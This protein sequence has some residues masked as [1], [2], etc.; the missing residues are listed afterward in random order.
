MEHS[1]KRK[2]PAYLSDYEASELVMNLDFG[3]ESEMEVD[4]NLS[5]S[6]R[7]FQGPSTQQL[8]PDA[9]I[10]GEEDSEDEDDVLASQ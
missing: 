3:A 8:E 10:G 1:R 7:G 6:E 5:E 2:A 9:D 4:V